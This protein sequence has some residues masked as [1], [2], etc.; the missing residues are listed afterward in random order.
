MSAVCG[1]EWPGTIQGGHDECPSD[2]R[3]RD[4]IQRSGASTARCVI[5]VVRTQTVVPMWTMKQVRELVEC[6]LRRS[7]VVAAWLGYGEPLFLEFARASG[8][9]RGTR[10]CQKMAD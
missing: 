7:A 5:A 8:T 2:A 9:R 1:A 6:E 4:T 3:K 10:K